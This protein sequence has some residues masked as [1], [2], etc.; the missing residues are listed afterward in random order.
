MPFRSHINL[1]MLPS[2]VR[3]SQIEA[4]YH[5]Q[6]QIISYLKTL[7]TK[8]SAPTT[9]DRY[10]LRA[11][12]LIPCP[13]RN[14]TTD[15]NSSRPTTPFLQLCQTTSTWKISQ[16]T[17]GVSLYKVEKNILTE[18]CRELENLLDMVL[19]QPTLPTSHKTPKPPRRPCCLPK[20]PSFS[21]ANDEG[22][23]TLPN[24]CYAAQ[25]KTSQALLP[26]TPQALKKFQST[27]AV[28]QGLS[29]YN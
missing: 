25:A 14:G 26:K 22:S 5:T 21:T 27:L 23:N 24:G 28:R 15:K 29:K 12:S 2:T 18:K 6:L 8:A 9:N 4:R 13:T 7:R 1:R 19:L 11:S 10:E 17:Q 3:Q 16:D 20:Q